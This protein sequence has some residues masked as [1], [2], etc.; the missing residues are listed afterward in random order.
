MHSV[1]SSGLGR[2]HADGSWLFV[3]VPKCGG[4]SVLHAIRETYPQPSGLELNGDHLVDKNT[5]LSLF[6]DR[7]SRAQ[8]VYGHRVFA[9]LGRLMPKPTRMVTV[10]RH[11]VDRA[12]SHYNFI[13]TRPLER[14]RVHGALTRDGVRIPF[15]DWLAEFPPAGNHLV[16]MLFQVL[17]DSPRVFDFS[18]RVGPEQF[19]VVSERIHQFVHLHLVEEGGVGTAI[20]QITAREPRIKNANRRHAV[21]PADLDARAAATAACH[22]DI[23]IYQLAKKI[24]K[25]CHCDA[26]CRS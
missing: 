15:A 20:R 21:D 23:A 13:L 11:P 26:A 12:I 4:S 9:G 16:W 18:Q 5:I 25:R 1:V 24:Q 7:L 22:F 10:L 2:E 19:R 3:H 8:V 14:Q 6:A 17:G